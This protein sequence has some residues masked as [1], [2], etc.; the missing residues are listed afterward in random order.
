MLSTCIMRHILWSS[1]AEF[2][3]PCFVSTWVN[4][5]HWNDRAITFTRYHLTFLDCFK[6]RYSFR[7]PWQI[8]DFFPLKQPPGERATMSPYISPLLGRYQVY[9]Y[10]HINYVSRIDQKTNTTFYCWIWRSSWPRRQAEQC[11]PFIVWYLY[12]QWIYRRHT[13]RSFGPLWCCGRS[14]VPQR[15]G[16]RPK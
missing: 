5:M 9:M 10:P 8:P 1:Y 7:T 3:M 15:Q 6:L 16:W 13:R 11:I 12:N 4:G 2:E 14:S